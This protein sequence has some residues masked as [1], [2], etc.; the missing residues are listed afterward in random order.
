MTRVWFRFGFALILGLGVLLFL[1][2]GLS[3]ATEL[4]ANPGLND[5]DTYVDTGRDWR[6]YDEK[7]A[8]GWWYYYVADGTYEADENAPKLHWMSS[9]QF[10]QAF[11]GLDYQRE[12]DAAQ[13]IWS[14]YDFDAGVYQGVTGLSVGRDYAFEVGIATYWRGPGPPIV[15]GKMVKCIGIDPY[16]G[17]DPTASSVIWDWD[18][19]DS[20][21][22][23]WV[24]LDMAATSQAITMTVFVRI[25]SP[26]NESF[27]HTDLNL[28]FIDDG[29][30]TLAPTATLTA[31]A[32]SDSN[33]DLQWEASAAP[34]WTLQGVE[35]QYKDHAEGVWHTIQGRT[36]TGTSH[37]LPGQAGHTY[38]IRARAWQE[39]GSYDLH[40]LWVEKQVQVGGAFVGHVR[41]NF[42][43]GVSGAV[44]STTGANTSSGSGG[45][46]AL[47]PPAYGQPYSLTVTAGN[48]Q[49]PPPISGTVAD[50]ISVTPI[51]FT[52]KPAND[53]II[54]GD[55]ESDTADWSLSG[56]G[57]AVVFSG[58]HRSGDASL[59]LSGVITLEQT[60]VI[61]GAHN[62]TLSFW[63][64]PSLSG[65]ESLQASL[66]G[67]TRLTSRTFSASAPVEWQHAWL[68]LNLHSPYSGSVTIS[69]RLSGGQ[70]FV[71]EASLGDGPY[72]TFFPVVLRR[73]Q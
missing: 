33:I 54:N 73:K 61:S 67:G 3:L 70:V 63:Y 18:N 20:T 28:V 5:P 66:Q 60:V 52:L 57:D 11:G 7:V 17:I 29:R 31:P 15:H 65:D 62:P 68:P 59:E 49:P 12:G 35:V 14:S 32:T 46:Y 45:F 38:T 40:G 25:Q 42:G 34:G 53:A 69:F 43:A 64:K 48:Y 23:T 37:V 21:D 30:L 24:Y 55:F 9:K 44:V 26:E 27:N 36:D 71:D 2:S 13:V 1:F 19:C 10:A 56:T 41:N 50:E 8:D 39:Q 4:L 6:E 58:D 51:N 47:Q 22:N 16:G 72:V